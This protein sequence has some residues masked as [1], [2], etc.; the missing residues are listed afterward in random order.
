MS[1]TKRAALFRRRGK[2]LARINAID[3]VLAGLPVPKLKRK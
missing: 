2:L 1:K 3:A